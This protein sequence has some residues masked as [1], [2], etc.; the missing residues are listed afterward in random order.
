MVQYVFICCTSPRHL[1]KPGPRCTSWSGNDN[2]NLALFKNFLLSESRGS[3][4]QFRAEFFNVWNHTQFLGDVA[5]GGISTN[6]GSSNFGA[7]TNAADPRTIN[8]A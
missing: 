7:I 2:W 5:N 4:L 8:L 1:G 6:F 3:N